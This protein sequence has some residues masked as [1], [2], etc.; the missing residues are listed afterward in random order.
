MLPVVIFAVVVMVAVHVGLLVTMD[1]GFLQGHL[2]DPDAYMRVVRVLELRQGAAWFDTITPALAAPEGLSLHWTRPL[3]ILILLPALA[4][5]QLGG[6]DP[7]QAIFLAGG[8]VSPPLHLAATLAAAW[9]AAGLWDRQRAPLYAVLMMAASPAAANYSAPGRADHHALILFAVTLGLAAAIH[10]LRPGARGGVA[11]VAGAAFGFGVWVG[12]EA[13][14]VALPVLLAIGLAALL[15]ED[16]RPAA[17]QGVRMTAGMA[18]MLLVAILVER[19]PSGWL[20]VETDRVSVEHLALAL[21]C[22]GAFMVLR[23]VASGPRLRRWL[24]GVAAGAAAVGAF[25]AVFPV[26]PQRVAEDADAAIAQMLRLHH[27]L[28]AEMQPLPPFGPGGVAT[29]GFLMGGVPVLGLLAI[30]LAMRG[31]RRDGSWPA[32]LVL[33]MTLL[34]GIAAAFAAVRFALDLAAPAAIAAAGVMGQ[35]L[36]RSW[37]REPALRLVLGLVLVLGCLAVPRLTRDRA[38]AERIGSAG[39]TAAIGSACDATALAA[40]LAGARQHVAPADH[41]PILVMEDMNA[42]PEIAWR[43][44]IRG[45][46]GPYHRGGDAFVDVLRAFTATDDGAARAIL[47]RRQADLIAVCTT[48]LPTDNAADFVTRLRRGEAP[49]WLRAIPLPDSLGGY[50]LFAVDPGA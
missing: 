43:S 6:L 37:P 25:V 2:A 47:R 41:A 45:V 38:E 18:A 33:G 7:R 10:A 13:L 11:M 17:T 26:L 5:E 8:L 50:R 44:G 42:G 22:S 30:A 15:A 34:A 14:I 21:L 48:D 9:G 12:P 29:A 35:V 24:V 3:D 16:G 20:A 23:P 36:A 1:P 4:L 39:G 49:P 28:I 19:P 46:S 31:W 40:W 27:D 32:G